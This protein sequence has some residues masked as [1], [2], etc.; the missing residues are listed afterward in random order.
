VEAVAE[1]TI[2]ERYHHTAVGV[3]VDEDHKVLN[4]Q[5]HNPGCQEQLIPVAVVGVELITEPRADRVLLLFVSK[6]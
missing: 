4:R 2:K 3:V 5:K 6:I 1:P